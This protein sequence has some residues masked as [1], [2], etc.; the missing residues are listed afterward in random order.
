MRTDRRNRLR[1]AEDLVS[2]IRGM[3]PG[4]K[5]KVRAALEAVLSDPTCGKALK[6]DLSGLRSFRIGH[7]R[8]IYK[9]SRA[10]VQVVAI[11][12]RSRIYEETSRLLKRE[13]TV[14]R[15]SSGKD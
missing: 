1:L 11:G 6:D 3:H 7:L 15:G 12:P 14:E 8:I 9:T 5:K 4:L 10:E 13:Q 2:L